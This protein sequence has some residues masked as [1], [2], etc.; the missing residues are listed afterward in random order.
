[1]RSTRRSECNTETSVGSPG[2]DPDRPAPSL[3]PP[4]CFPALRPTHFHRTRNAFFCLRKVGAKVDYY[5]THCGRGGQQRWKRGG[6]P[7]SIPSPFFP[8]SSAGALTTLLLLPL[9]EACSV[10]FRLTTI[11]T[12]TP[13]DLRGRSLTSLAAAAAA[14]AVLPAHLRRCVLDSAASA[15]DRVVHALS[16]AALLSSAAV[17]V[18]VQLAAARTRH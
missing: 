12:L 6:A 11:D 1:M 4:P 2:D 17:L 9:F 13:F 18:P 7:T 10:S 14:A 16:I 3:P 5:L 8:H 15:D